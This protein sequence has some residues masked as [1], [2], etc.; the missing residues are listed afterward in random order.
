MTADSD[1]VIDQSGHTNR[2]DGMRY[3]YLGLQLT[4]GALALICA[5]WLFG[6]V[7]EDVVHGDPLNLVDVGFRADKSHTG[8]GLLKSSLVKTRTTP[9][10]AL[11]VYVPLHTRRSN[12]SVRSGEDWP[13]PV[14]WFRSFT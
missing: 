14:G 4:A 9:V 10:A 6:G 3:G 2:H 5:T 12:L 11:Q 1:D 8:T 7:A 13:A